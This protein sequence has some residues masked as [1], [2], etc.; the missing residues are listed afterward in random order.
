MIRNFFTLLIVTLM[1]THGAMGQTF[2]TEKLDAYFSS[3]EAADKLM[4]SVLLVQDGDI[5]YQRSLGYADLERKLKNNSSTAYRIGSISKMFTAVLVLQAVEEGVLQLDEPIVNYFPEIQNSRQITI[6][7]LLQHRSGIKSFTENPAYLT[8]HTTAQTRDSLYK[9]IL[10][11]GS[12][13]SPD[14]KANYSNANY[15]LLTWLL[16]DVTGKT[17][18]NLLQEKIIKP[19][20]LSSTRLGSSS[21]NSDANQALSYTMLADWTVSQETD[22]SIPLGAGAIISNLSDLTLF[23]QGLFDGKLLKTGSLE[24]M[25]DIKDGFGLGML[26]IPFYEHMSYGH[27]G[28]IDGFRSMLG[29][30][31]EQ[32]F[33]LAIVSNG[34]DYD[35]NLAALAALSAYFGKDFEVPTFEE[36]PI[37]ESVLEQL[38]GVYKSSIFPLEITI[39]RKGNRL[40]AQATGQSEFP[41]AHEGDYLFSFN[42]ANLTMQFVP[43]E[44]TMTFKQGGMTFEFSKKP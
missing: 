18:D 13:F 8:W 29:Y 40:M 16:E 33:T 19:L 22:L 41:L 21:I 6:Q 38:I 15:V 7:H 28:G 12:E 26:K 11:Q 14:S 10:A 44:G 43:E 42:A 27:T 36:E 25:K 24:R 1:L 34:A 30:F 5:L 9:I 17:Y 20:Q 2:S 4:G 23:I 37:E 35:I 3:L 39:S 31:P 32:K